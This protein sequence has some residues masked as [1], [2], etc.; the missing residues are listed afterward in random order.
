[1]SGT[2]EQVGSFPRGISVIADRRRR[3]RQDPADK[4]SWRDVIARAKMGIVRVLGAGAIPGALSCATLARVGRIIVIAVRKDLPQLVPERG[5]VY[6][7]LDGQLVR[8]VKVT[9]NLCTWVP[10]AQGNA[11]RQVTHRDY[12]LRRFT[13]LKKSTQ[14]MAA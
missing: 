14:E 2:P 3:R 5:A 9:K 12:F 4:I 1:V 7:D 8:L 6:R 11:A 10:I 13:P